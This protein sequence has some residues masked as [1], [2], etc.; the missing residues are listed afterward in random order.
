[1]KSNQPVK[2]AFAP[3]KPRLVPIPPAPA[4]AP[5]AAQVN[6]PAVKKEA[7]T[8][9]KE[10][11]PQQPAKVE[12]PFPKQVEIWLEIADKTGRTSIG[13]NYLA[14]RNDDARAMVIVLN[15]EHWLVKRSLEQSDA[16]TTTLLASLALAETLQIRKRQAFVEA[17]LSEVRRTVLTKEEQAVWGGIFLGSY[18]AEHALMQGIATL[19]IYGEQVSPA[20]RH[21]IATIKLQ[22]PEPNQ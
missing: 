10:A 4:P 18:L 13:W 15:K 19:P 17:T 6:P 12:E 22:P 1:M 21:W 8:P 9:E 16:R 14:R 7:I 5:A 2:S 3:M 20:P 11:T